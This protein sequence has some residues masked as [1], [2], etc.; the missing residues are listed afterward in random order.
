MAK[1]LDTDGISYYLKQIINNAQ[2]KLVLISPYL[3]FNE[4]LKDSLQDKD[5]FKIDIRIIYGKSELQPSELNWLK[6]LNSIRTSFCKELH[7]KCYLNEK[8][9]IITSMNLYDY[10]QRNNYEM[11][12]FIEKSQDSELYKNVYEEVQR[13]IRNSEEVKISVSKVTNSFDKQEKSIKP[14]A[15][16][17]GFCIRCHSEIKLSPMVPYCK[18]CYKIWQIAKN[19]NL[20]EKYCHICGKP[21]KPSLLK[22]TCYDCYK[23]FKDTLEFPLATK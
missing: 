14:K 11:G 1:F 23:S 7:A 9:A 8:E 3:R 16:S 4:L 17:T 15:D 18:S 2:D 19:E 12:I 20:E 5:R 22:P 21:G 13:L 10:S 6:S